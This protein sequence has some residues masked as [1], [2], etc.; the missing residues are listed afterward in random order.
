MW[1][2]MWGSKRPI[3]GELHDNMKKP[4]ISQM[5]VC[6]CMES[7]WVTNC[8]CVTN[9]L[10]LWKRES[11]CHE[12][13]HRCVCVR[14]WNL[15]GSRTAYVSRTLCLCG[16]EK[17]NATSDVCK[18]EKQR[19][20]ALSFAQVQAKYSEIAGLLAAENLRSLNQHHKHRNENGNL[21]R[22]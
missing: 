16:K 18:V 17:A 10:S 20:N 9:T 19:L 1:A 6:T 8:V 15:H 22:F 7:T 12:W 3:P 11:E 2:M 4:Q 5:C 14:V 13:S 21:W